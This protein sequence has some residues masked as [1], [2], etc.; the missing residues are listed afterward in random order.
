[1]AISVA[2][3]LSQHR[4]H[5][6]VLRQ[7]IWKHTDVGLRPLIRHFPNLKTEVNHVQFWPTVEPNMTVRKN[8]EVPDIWPGIRRL[9]QSDQKCRDNPPVHLLVCST[10]S[11]SV[12]SLSETPA[13]MAGV[14]RKV[15]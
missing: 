6:F 8:F 12:H 7:T 15:R 1:M 3:K 11:V 13:A 5:T 14:T 9:H 2:L 4:C 10:N